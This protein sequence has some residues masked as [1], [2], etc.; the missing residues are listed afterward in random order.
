MTASEPYE[1]LLWPCRMCMYQQFIEAL[2][3][4][5]YYIKLLRQI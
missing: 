5:L 4:Q 3:D 1:L 2:S